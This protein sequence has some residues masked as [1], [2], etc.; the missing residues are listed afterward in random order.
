MLQH[1]KERLYVTAKRHPSPQSFIKRTENFAR[2]AAGRSR[3]SNGVISPLFDETR[4]T[5]EGLE[6]EFRITGQVHSA[7]A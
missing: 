1:L 7:E 2:Y 6:E 3:F 5:I 4:E